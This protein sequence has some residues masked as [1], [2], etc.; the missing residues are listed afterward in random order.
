MPLLH[1]LA[2]AFGG[3]VFCVP[4]WAADIDARSYGYPLSNPF[5]ATIA[6]TP[7]NLRPAL[8]ADADIEQA[9]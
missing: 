5:E 6:T 1:R 7:P 2:A 3:L 4:L 8:P 9:D